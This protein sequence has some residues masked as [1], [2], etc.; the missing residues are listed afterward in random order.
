MPSSP[1]LSVPF[2]S[3]IVPAYN[4][5]AR[6][7]ASLTAITDYLG[8]Q[9]Y[10][11]EAYPGARDVVTDDSLSKVSI[12]GAGMLDAPGYASRMFRALADADINIDM[13]TTSEIR[14]TCIVPESRVEDAVQ[15]LHRAFQ[16]EEP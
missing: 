9:N 14:I 6:I 3:V 10:S 7:S 8:G 13:I 11:W 15:V 4:E 16:L 2:L 5:E 12:V 1:F